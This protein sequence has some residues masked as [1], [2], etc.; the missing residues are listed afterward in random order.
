MAKTLRVGMTVWSE[1]FGRGVVVGRGV[2]EY[3]H[4]P[5]LMLKVRL[6]NDEQASAE[7]TSW[8]AVR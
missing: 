1:Q 3:E 7:A 2:A 6:E 8:K 5:V 4:G